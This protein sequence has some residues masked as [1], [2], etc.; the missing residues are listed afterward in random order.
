MTRVMIHEVHTRH[1]DQRIGNIDEF[2]S[3]DI[4]YQNQELKHYCT[5]ITTYKL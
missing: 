1:A 3:G 2:N 5:G 4:L